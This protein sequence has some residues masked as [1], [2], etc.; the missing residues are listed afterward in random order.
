MPRHLRS[1]PDT[2]SVSCV[3]PMFNEREN[4]GHALECIVEALERHAPDYEV[5][6]VDDASTDDSAAIVRGA[7]AANP[8]IRLLRH[9]RNRKLGATIRTGVRAATKDLVLYMDADLPV[10]PDTLGRA[11]R[12]MRV[13]R[14]HVIAGY[15]FDRVPEGLRRA[16]YSRAY[17]TLIGVLFGWPFRDINFAFKLFRRE[18]FEA[19]DIRSEGSL[20]DAELIIKAKNCGFVV[21]QIGVDYFPRAYGQSHLA[22][23]GV[24]FRILRE[25]MALYPDMRRPSPPAPS[26]APALGPEQSSEARFR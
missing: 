16:L 7:A 1:L 10:D 24:I 2:P 18:V 11:L 17:N 8:H 23:P 13:T 21:Q 5:V 22:S 4:I 12:A 26:A 15:R 6:V 9:D 19:F 20:I 25:L 3:L 14:A